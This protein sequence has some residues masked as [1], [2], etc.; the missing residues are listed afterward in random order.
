MRFTIRDGEI[1]AD[2]DGRNDGR[3]YY[4]CPDH[5]CLDV[6]IKKKIFNRILKKNVDPDA[7]KKIIEPMLDNTKEE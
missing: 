2:S 3:G 4:I 1:K 6:A 5:N 7:L